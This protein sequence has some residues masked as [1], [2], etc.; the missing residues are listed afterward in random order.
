MNKLLTGL[1]LALTTLAAQASPQTVDIM[2]LYTKDAL[3]LP[4]G[5]DI[6]ARIA[7][8]IEYTN[9]AYAKSGTNLRLRLVHKQLL[10]WAT[11]YDVS[12]SNLSGF[13]NDAQVQRLREQYGADVVQLLNRTT[14]GQG[15][16]VCGIAWVG[17]GAKNSDQFYSNAKDMA[18]GLTGIDC[19]LSTFAHEIGH[20]MGLRH[21]YEQDLQSGYYQS[22]SGTHEWSRGYGVQGQF[23]TIMGY[24]QV[25]GARRQAPLFSN[26]RL[27]DSECAGQ[28]CGQHDH[29]DASRA[30]NSMATQI[31]NFR[32]TQVPVTG[33]PT[34]PKPE[35]P[36]CSKPA[37]KGLVGNGEFRT[38]DGW[39]ALFGNADLSLVNVATDCRDN[40]LQ[41]TTQG[42][43]MLATP[44]SG[45]RSGVQYRLKAKAMLK[46][47]NSRENVRL[48]LLSE[49]TE[50]RLNYS[51]EQT[52]SLS[53]TG[54]E[55]SLLE[56][57]FTYKPGNTA[58][59]NQYVAIWSDSGSSLLVD[60]V[61]LL[62]VATTPP[63]APPPPTKFSWS[64]E[65][66]IG[67][68]AGFHGSNRAST[69]ASRSRKALEVY[70]RKQEGA[71]ATVSLLGKIK[72]GQRYRFSTDATVGRSKTVSA[73]A[74][75]YL[76]LVDSKG[77]AQQIALSQKKT[78]GGTWSKLQKDVQIP[79]GSFRRIDLRIVGSQKGQSLFIDNVSLNKL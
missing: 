56:K 5:R 32:P 34:D 28:A 29:A 41:V 76:Y 27:I 66:S 58:L 57:A 40:A 12:G 10:D 78:A 31:A 3:A 75:A 55:F 39:V 22:H 43:D 8:Y 11:Y 9:N 74:Y 14:Q 48:A 46:A 73:T 60:E 77:R 67:G 38:S 1:S 13:T 16:G 26:P 63:V 53:L 50:G 52:V 45:L 33:T 61:Q 20:N 44:V 64:F 68:W 23:S 49:D 19:G 2:V 37:L 71:G 24:P 6:D 4:N 69:F 47:A 62:E 79:A 59:R 36:W 72:P 25:F 30:L 17:T 35:L 21:S 18:Y 70:N 42:F 51:D 15:Y 7:S 65:S 54:N